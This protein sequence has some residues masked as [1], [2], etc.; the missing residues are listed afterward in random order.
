MVFPNRIYNLEALKEIKDFRLCIE[1]IN[2]WVFFFVFDILTTEVM[3]KEHPGGFSIKVGYDGA[4][5][6]FEDTPCL[7]NGATGIAGC[8]QYAIRPDGV[9]CVIGKRQVESVGCTNIFR[10]DFFELKMLTSDCDGVGSQV[11]C[12]DT[13]ATLQEFQTIVTHATTD[14]EQVFSLEEFCFPINALHNPGKLI[15]VHPR[16][17]MGKKF[18]A[19]GLYTS[20][21]YILKAQR[22]RIPIVVNFSN[23]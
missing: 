7:L 10:L 20:I 1:L 5:A 23:G 9:K 15:G 3:K 13:H 17:D 14:F 12:S 8:M 4:S 11:G 18:R 2:R 19:T 16:T 21:G 6:Y 22:V